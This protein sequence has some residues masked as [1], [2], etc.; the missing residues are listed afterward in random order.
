MKITHVAATNWRNFKNLEF[1]VAD[2]LFVV[3]P[4]ASGK[5]NLLDI[6]RFL[7]DGNFAFLT[8]KRI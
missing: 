4:N 1:D 5:S 6:F 7:A 8:K 3:G 2:R